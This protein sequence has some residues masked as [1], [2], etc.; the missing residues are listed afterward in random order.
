MYRSR[1][2]IRLR[3][4]DYLCHPMDRMMYFRGRNYWGR[5]A[6][7]AWYWAMCYNG[8]RTIRFGSRTVTKTERGVVCICVSLSFESLLF[9]GSHCYGNQSRNDL[10]LR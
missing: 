9:F 6:K 5:W 3:L 7:N 8:I 10:D 1:G 2:S 4:D